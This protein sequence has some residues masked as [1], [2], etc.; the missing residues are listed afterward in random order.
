MMKIDIPYPDGAIPVL[1][2]GSGWLAVDKPAG[3]SIHN[4]PGADLISIVREHIASAG[5]LARTLNPDPS[6]GI[7]PVH[8][9]DRDTSGVTLLACRSG[10]FRHFS[11]QFEYHTA[12]KRYI[13]LLHGRLAGADEAGVWRRPL[14][15]GA[16]GRQRPAG[17]GPKAACETRF[18]VLEHGDRYTLAACMPVTGRKH[19]I[20][21]HAKMAGHPVVGDRR[22]GSKRA[23][24]YLSE[25]HNFTRLALH[26]DSLTIRPPENPENI[27][28]QSTGLPLEIRRLFETDRSP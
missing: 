1:D 13:V 4:D 9:L 26:A 10:T 11:R 8:R 19:Q 14:S 21:R 24:A 25:Y 18:T 15:R 6:F 22:Y 16:A 12:T 28:I 23:V 7:A 5:D 20:R 27:T 3:M 2:A 17:T